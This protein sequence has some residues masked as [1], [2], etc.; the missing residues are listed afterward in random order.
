MG[1]VTDI[2]PGVKGD[3]HKTTSID[4]LVLHRGEVVLH[5]EGG[6]QKTIK[7]GEATGE[8]QQWVVPKSEVGRPAGGGAGWNRE[9]GVI[10]S[11]DHSSVGFHGRD[12]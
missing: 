6:V 10:R 8:S 7:E 9:E 4:F 1:R 5:L 2:A 12:I 3:M 11:G